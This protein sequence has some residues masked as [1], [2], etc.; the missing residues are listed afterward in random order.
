MVKWSI[1]CCISDRSWSKL[2]ITNERGYLRENIWKVLVIRGRVIIWRSKSCT[3]RESGGRFFDLLFWR[4]DSW[5]WEI[6]LFGCFFLGS[7]GLRSEF[8]FLFENILSKKISLEFFKCDSFI[9]ILI[10][11]SKSSLNIRF[12]N[13]NSIF[14]KEIINPKAGS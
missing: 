8:D 1:N 12:R 6:T 9:P 4:Q 13:Q 11:T 3:G 7:L 5:S 14:L 2:R 10:H